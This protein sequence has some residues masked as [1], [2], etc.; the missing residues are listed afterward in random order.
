MLSGSTERLDWVD[1]AKGLSII[2]VVMMHSAYGVGEQLGDVGIWHW[3]IAWATPFRMPE[4]FLISGLFLGHVIAR[5]WLRFTD[6]RI[7]H[8]L[9]FY[10]LWVVLQVA[11]KVGL[12]TGDVM[13]ALEDIVIATVVP[14]G[15]LWFIYMLAFYGLTA[16]LLFELKVPH[17]ATLPIAAAL[18]M[19]DLKTGNSLVDHYAA[20]FVY[21]YA[22]YALAPV[23]FRLVAAAQHRAG[24]AIAV[25]LGYALIEGLLVFAGGFEFRLRG[26]QMGYAALPGIHLMLAIAGALGVCVTAALLIRLPH[27]SWLRWLGANSIVI[28]VSFSIPM[29]ALRTLLL[30]YDVSD[31]VSL[32]STI[33][34]VVS[35][36]APL[37]VYAVVRRTGWG[38]FLFERPDWAHLPG[39]RATDTRRR[40]T[41]IAAE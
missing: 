27:T 35:L 2:L 1:A 12:G 21:F 26:V 14:Y 30:R 38:R 32:V 23:I 20:Y 34:M 28:Y 5:P 8:Y 25:L 29:A 7:V 11:F 18:Q 16:K 15:V 17:W 10:A 4:F 3:V 39:A 36:L 37:V 19:L 41:I 31:N 24:L 33:V 13:S 40:E 6:R 22:G 9:Y